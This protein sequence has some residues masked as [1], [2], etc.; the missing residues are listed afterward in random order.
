MTYEWF[1]AGTKLHL[2][3]ND[4]YQNTLCGRHCNGR[5]QNSYDPTYGIPLCKQCN[6]LKD[7]VK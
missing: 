4:D 5:S 6:K 2:M 7:R 3:Q 1:I